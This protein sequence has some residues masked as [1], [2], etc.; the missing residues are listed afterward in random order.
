MSW[1]TARAGWTRRRGS[2]CDHSNAVL[3]VAQADVVSL[4]SASRIRAFLEEGGTRDRVRIIL[5]RYKKIPGFTD[6]DVE[7]ATSCKLLWKI[8]NNYQSIAPAID[9]GV[10]VAFQENTDI[11]RSFRSLAGALAQAAPTAD[12]SLDLSYQS[13]KSDPG[14]KSAG[15]LLISPLRAGQ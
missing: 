1:S 2:L 11:G 13:E 5:N 10:P 3:L 6:E 4:W 12:G 15:R 14:K 7:K 8:P 9:K